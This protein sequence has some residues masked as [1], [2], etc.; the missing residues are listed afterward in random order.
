MS[1]SFKG[2]ELELTGIEN[3]PL[4]K[5]S[6]LRYLYSDLGGKFEG[7]GRGIHGNGFC[8]LIL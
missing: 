5:R 3:N 6:Y 2:D 7:V 4:P 8:S 1:V